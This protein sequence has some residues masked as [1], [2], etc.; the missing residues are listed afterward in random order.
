MH[1]KKTAMS[2][3]I[4]SKPDRSQYVDLL[5]KSV[6]YSLN[7]FVYTL[8]YIL[9]L[10]HTRGGSQAFYPILAHTRI[11]HLRLPRANSFR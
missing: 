11:C 2:L 1:G 3:A 9:L 7:G 10:Y 4:Q 5:R 8:L 6:C